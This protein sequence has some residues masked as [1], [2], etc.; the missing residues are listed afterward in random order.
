MDYMFITRQGDQKIS[1]GFLLFGKDGGTRVSTLWLVFFQIVFQWTGQDWFNAI[2]GTPAVYTALGIED[3]NE[4][5]LF[6]NFQQKLFFSGMAVASIFVAFCSKRCPAVPRQEIKKWS[7]LCL[8]CALMA[9]VPLFTHKPEHARLS[10]L[11][12]KLVEGIICAVGFAN[13]ES[14]LVQT[15]GERLLTE[16]PP[17]A[18]AVSALGVG[19]G[20]QMVGWVLS[21]GEGALSPLVTFPIIYAITNA[22]VGHL[23]YKAYKMEVFDVDIK[24][25]ADTLMN[26][27][28]LT[29]TVFHEH[30]E[31]EQY[32]LQGTDCADP[33]F[34]LKIDISHWRVVPAHGDLMEVASYSQP[35]TTQE[36]SWM[37]QWMELLISHG[38]TAP[39]S[40]EPRTF[41]FK[42]KSLIAADDQQNQIG[43]KLNTAVKMLG[44]LGSTIALI[45]VGD[46]AATTHLHLESSA[47]KYG[48]G[49]S[50]SESSSKVVNMAIGGILVYALIFLGRQAFTKVCNLNKHLQNVCQLLFAMG[51]WYVATKAHIILLGMHLP[52][53]ETHADTADM[54]KLSSLTYRMSGF[55]AMSPALKTVIISNTVDIHEFQ[56]LFALQGFAEE[57]GKF[58]QT[59]IEPLVQQMVEC[60][61]DCDKVG[62]AAQDIA[63]WVLIALLFVIVPVSIIFQFVQYVRSRSKVS[64][65]MSEPL[66]KS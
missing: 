65:R 21:H 45:Q 9:F 56:H 12:N 27:D 13:N 24:E 32:W 5:E 57:S 52:S 15:M 61:A 47:S 35:Q 54:L 18:A 63:R 49:L 60:T 44:F 30:G 6:I 53:S 38:H 62:F 58:L 41:L 50:S 22:V 14:D 20:T 55:L 43:S 16:L 36:Q 28:Q 64:G 17:F 51:V 40:G 23:S 2:S 37:P 29:F 59:I 4:M 19:V 11:V 25:H 46:M 66:L 31:K 39:T 26:K 1:Y 10:V 48:L 7:A 34:Q 8:L 42:R 33:T 3:Q